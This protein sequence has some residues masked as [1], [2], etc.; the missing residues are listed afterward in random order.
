MKNAIRSSYSAIHA[1]LKI[2]ALV[3]PALIVTSLTAGT[4]DARPSTKSFT[5]DDVQDYVE[6]R[7]AVV[8]NTKNRSIYRRFVANSSYC[9]FSEITKIYVAPTR[10]GSC[11]M[12]ICV[13]KFRDR[14]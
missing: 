9:R 3:L 7:G 12:R 8:M 4:A 13:S 10:S 1:P 5:C 14:R 6:D 2:A 11:Y